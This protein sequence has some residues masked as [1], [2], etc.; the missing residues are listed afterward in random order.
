M[1]RFK[2]KYPAIPTQLAHA[3]DLPALAA[4]LNAIRER[5][6]V[7]SRDRGDVEDSMVSVQDLIELGLIT[8]EQAQ[9]LKRR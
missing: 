7:F 5:V 4:I 1:A 2:H 9:G 8:A 3:G 6:E